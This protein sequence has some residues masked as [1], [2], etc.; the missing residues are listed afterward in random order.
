MSALEGVGKHPTVLSEQTPVLRVSFFQEL[1]HS[2]VCDAVGAIG[3]GSVGAGALSIGDCA[4]PALNV[5][6]DTLAQ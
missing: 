1:W 5:V 3:S 2:A 4:A 6:V